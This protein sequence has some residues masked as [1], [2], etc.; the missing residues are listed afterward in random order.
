MRH[1]VITTVVTFVIFC[2]TALIALGLYAT[3]PKAGNAEQPQ[4]MEQAN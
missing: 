3:F 4:Q 1:L 2:T